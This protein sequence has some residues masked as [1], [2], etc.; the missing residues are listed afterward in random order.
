M[1]PKAMILNELLPEDAIISC[2][3]TF[4]GE[5]L[6]DT[7]AHLYQS[8][9]HRGGWRVQRVAQEGGQTEGG[10]RTPSADHVSRRELL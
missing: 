4:E 10:T 8:K 1:H 9:Q 5:D 2:R 3:K 6:G 7:N